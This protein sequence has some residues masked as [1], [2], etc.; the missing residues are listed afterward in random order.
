ML[1]TPCSVSFYS[2]QPIPPATQL[3]DSVNQG[4]S[5]VKKMKSVL[6]NPLLGLGQ[7]NMGTAGFFM[8]SLSSVTGTIK[9]SMIKSSVN[10][11]NIQDLMDGLIIILF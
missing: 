1:N 3:M 5:S 7:V 11:D 4:M 2:V 10:L 8:K 6:A 9:N